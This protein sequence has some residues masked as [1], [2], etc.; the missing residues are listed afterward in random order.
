M[1]WLGLVRLGYAEQAKTLCTRLSAAVA[2][3]GLREYYD[4][5]DGRGM[6]QVD[7]G[8]SSLLLELLEHDPRS[9]SSYLSA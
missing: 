1:L 5:Y 3:A 4:P 8:W 7:F 6:G 9:R 2:A